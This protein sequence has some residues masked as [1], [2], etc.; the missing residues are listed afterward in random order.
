[1]RLDGA[2]ALLALL[3]ALLQPLLLLAGPLLLLLLAL[4]QPPLLLCG[5][6]VAIAGR[7]SGAAGRRCRAAAAAQLQGRQP[8]GGSLCIA[9]GPRSAAG[10]GRAI[11]AGRFSA[12]L[13]A[14]ALL[15]LVVARPAPAAALLCQDVRANPAG[16]GRLGAVGQQAWWGRGALGRAGCGA[17]PALGGWWGRAGRHG[18]LE[19]CPRHVD[20]ELAG[21]EGAGCAGLELRSGCRSLGWASAGKLKRNA[22]KAE[23]DKDR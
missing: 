15:A 2:A 22:M 19:G 13:L 12:C 7:T 4:L 8:G 10:A 20:R 9:S 23:V 21:A 11:Q 16:L 1:M 5:A 6:V 17:G 18:R 3:A 14:A